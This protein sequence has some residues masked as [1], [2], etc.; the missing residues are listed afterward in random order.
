M[1]IVYTRNY[2]EYLKKVASKINNL[3]QIKAWEKLSSTHKNSLIKELNQYYHKAK[4]KYNKRQLSKVLGI[5]AIF[6]GLNVNAQ[7]F[8]SEQVNP[9]NIKS[10][11]GYISSPD[12]VDIDNDG[13]LDLFNAAYDTN[14]GYIDNL[15]F[16]ENIGSASSPNFD[17]S[18]INPFNFN[19][20]SNYMIISPLFADIDNDG[21][22]D[23]LATGYYGTPLFFENIGTASAP[24]FG[25]VQTSPFSLSF[26]YTFLTDI[27]DLDNDGD[28]DLLGFQSVY[29][30][31][32]NFVYFENT[33]NATSPSFA[34]P[35]SNP[36]GLT[37]T[38]SYYFSFGALSDIDKDGDLDIL[39]TDYYTSN[40]F[41]HENTGTASSPSFAN[42]NGTPSPFSL[43]T[44]NYL[45]FPR[46]AD[47]DGD[48]DEDLFAGEYYGNTL[49]YE[50]TGF[51]NV[52]EIDNQ[53][54]LSLFPNPTNDF[55]NISIKTKKEIEVLTIES[56]DGKVLRINTSN[57]EKLSID[58]SDLK[59]GN[60]FLK[61]TTKSGLIISKSFSKIE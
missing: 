39:R 61:A 31:P 48:G 33:G 7:N 56:I 38:S 35:V 12:F 11:G 18:V 36:F 29:N 13:D 16:Q 40:F 50:N 47:I 8:G 19:L 27:A 37:A 28:F 46:F 55:L 20:G 24:N 25:T 4:T 34:S 58:V 21:D 23:L 43:S 5:C 15:V 6:V 30:G 42:G 49:F 10:T 14:S 45:G 54:S 3:I 1:K 44:T 57:K 22:F 2:F 60:Y 41:Y 32:S 17:D 53:N 9:F 26:N 51:A 52:D 59:P